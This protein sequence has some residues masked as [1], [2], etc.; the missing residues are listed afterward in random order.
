MLILLAM[1]IGLV[2]GLRTMTAPA[3]VSWAAYLGWFDIS[4]SLLS[5]MDSLW[6]VAI[7]TV[8]A[9]VE[10]IADQLPGTPS[11][12]VPV[13]FGA[14]VVMGALSGA[15][16]GATTGMVVPGLLAG[17]IGAVLGTFGG[18]SLRANL[19]KRFGRDMPAALVE[20]AVAVLLA[21]IVV[22]SVS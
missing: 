14:R 22:V 1:L 16:I 3:A 5:F 15:T 8:F 2:A 6:A 9:I 11:R 10:L 7:F 19:A 13:Q 17:G 21:L 12:K 20:D 18:A 4:A